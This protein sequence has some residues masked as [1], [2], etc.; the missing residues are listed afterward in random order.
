MTIANEIPFKTI[1]E[2][3]GSFSYSNLATS[4]KHRGVTKNGRQT[5]CVNEQ[6]LTRARQSS[7]PNTAKQPC[8]CAAGA[9]GGQ[10]PSWPSHRRCAV[11]GGSASQ[12]QLVCHRVL[13]RSQNS[14]PQKRDEHCRGKGGVSGPSARAA[15]AGPLQA[16]AQ[17]F[18]LRN[19]HGDSD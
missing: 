3:S 10:E 2:C 1:Q 18:A 4:I 14:R 16:S 11:R 19:F 6:Y 9:S 5:A 17:H 15:E 12:G 13:A 7:I 8:H